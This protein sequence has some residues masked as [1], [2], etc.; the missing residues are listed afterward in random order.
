MSPSI[1]T[2]QSPSISLTVTATTTPSL[3]VTATTTPSLTVT[4]SPTPSSLLGDAAE[5][6]QNSTALQGFLNDMFAGPPVDPGQLTAIAENL[7]ADLPT[8]D[9]KNTLRLLAALPK[10]G[11][12]ANETFEIKTDA[13]QF[14]A[15]P[16]AFAAAGADE[17]TSVTISTGAGLSIAVPPLPADIAVPGL[18]ASVIVW[19]TN[20]FGAAGGEPLNT[21]VLSFELSSATGESITVKNLAK[22]FRFSY[23]LPT[24]TRA[25]RLPVNLTYSCISNDTIL[26]LE[27][28]NGTTSQSLIANTTCPDGSPMVNLTCPITDAPI[29]IEQPNW[30]NYTCPAPTL[31]GSCIYWDTTAAN[32]SSDG[33]RAA[34]ADADTMVCECT[35][36]TDFGGRIRAIAASNAALFRSFLSIYTLEALKSLWPFY[37]FFGAWAVTA[38]ITLIVLARLDRKAATKYLARLYTCTEIQELMKAYPP[39]MHLDRCISSEEDAVFSATEWPTKPPA[40][41]PKPPT[42]FASRTVFLAKLYAQRF[43]YQHSYL[44]VFFRYDPRL[45]R[46][47]RAIFIFTSLFHTLFIT[48]LLYGFTHGAPAEGEA[49]PPMTV[50]ETVVNTVATS[51]L[52]VIFMRIFFTL[53]NSAGSAEFRWR[54]PI[55]Y[56]E[57]LRRHKIEEVLC[58][59]DDTELAREINRLRR[60]RKHRLLH[61]GPRAALTEYNLQDAAA[62][63]DAE[64]LTVGGGADSTAQEGDFF[65]YLAMIVRCKRRPKE[66]T[67]RCCTIEQ[68]KSYLTLTLNVPKEPATACQR[69]FVVHTVRGWIGV[70][71]PAAWFAW[72]IQYLLAF[73]VSRRPE[74]AGQVFQTYGLSQF[75][76]IFIT[77]PITLAA[78]IGLTLFFFW[79]TQ[80]CCRRGGKSQV[81]VTRIG[82]KALEFFSD[83]MAGKGSTALSASFAYWLFLRAPADASLSTPWTRHMDIACATAKAATGYLKEMV[84]RKELEPAEEDSEEVTE[85]T[86]E[87]GNTD[88]S[89]DT[90]DVGEP[91][92]RSCEK[93]TV[94]I[95]ALWRGFVA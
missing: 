73:A 11:M 23:A 2:S 1:T 53:M 88:D 30:R 9:V 86:E 92:E 95:Y 32:W 41:A 45:P 55:L 90:I 19:T 26:L 7:P 28:S 12:G 6:L 39:D 13:F 38:L 63:E 61:N 60:E 72:C 15:V 20:P 16:L 21:P 76:T 44:S 80:R 93:K 42:G 83:P 82:T 68:A 34:Y 79:L 65:E 22:P 17:N 29:L 3:T 27:S 64:M 33:C 81:Q 56:E 48:T 10:A 49:L 24:E 47:F 57:L 46:I 66:S 25:S 69:W 70:I 89:I 62:R 54:Y 31:E 50:T 59:I 14:I 85:D 4:I 75:T 58:D 87:V 37:A 74:V 77:Q 35:H 36:L 84:V 78:T 52:N 43:F 91:T 8:E 5:V 94:T 71:V 67:D 18:S 51:A 40:A